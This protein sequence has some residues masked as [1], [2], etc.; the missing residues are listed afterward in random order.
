MFMFSSGSHM[1]RQSLKMT[2]SCASDKSKLRTANGEHGMYFVEFR[3]QATGL[4]SIY[5]SVAQN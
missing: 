3:F 4:D 5:S 2:A 1:I